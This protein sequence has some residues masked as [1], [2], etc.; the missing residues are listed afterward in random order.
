MEVSDRRWGGAHLLLSNTVYQ[1][2]CAQRL[3]SIPDIV[4]SLGWPEVYVWQ[5]EMF[6]LVYIVEDRV[7][8]PIVK[9]PLLLCP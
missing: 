2:L 5:M 8:L 7:K 6:D 9:M 3:N 1:S 4:R